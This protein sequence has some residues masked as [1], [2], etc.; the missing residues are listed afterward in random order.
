MFL[1]LNVENFIYSFFRYFKKSTNKYLITLLSKLF[2]FVFYFKINYWKKFSFNE[3]V[4][5]L[6]SFEKNFEYFWLDLKKKNKKLILSKSPNWYNWHIKYFRN[7]WIT[8]LY[9]NNSVKGYAVCC[10]RSNNKYQ[11]KKFTI[12]DV[13]VSESS[14]ESYIP[15]IINSIKKGHQLGYD[16]VDMIGTNQIKRNMFS[17]LKTFKKN[18][19]NFL[20]YY[21][22]NNESIMK[23]LSDLDI[24]DITLFDGDNF[25]V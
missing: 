20:F 18:N 24:W 13:V 14:Q 10:E 8:T 15:L 11:L 21:Y 16:I 9:Q 2:K 25:I 23:A 5:F 3:K 22:S 1:I 4:D 6:K 19:S 17:T 12:V 7:F